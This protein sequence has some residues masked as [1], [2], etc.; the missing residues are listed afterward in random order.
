MLVEQGLE[1]CTTIE[2]IEIN[3]PSKSATQIVEGLN[4]G[5][6]IIITEG[7]KEVESVVVPA[8]TFKTQEGGHN[9]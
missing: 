6:F 7:I 8:T 2:R 4:A 9:H 3:W 1:N 5:E